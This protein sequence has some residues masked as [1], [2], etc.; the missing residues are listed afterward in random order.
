MGANGRGRQARYD[1][2]PAPANETR[3]SSAGATQGGKLNSLNP[4]SLKSDVREVLLSRRK[5]KLLCSSYLQAS[6]TRTS[7]TEA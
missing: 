4:Q 2:A 1:T 7:L 6:K 5:L 3:F